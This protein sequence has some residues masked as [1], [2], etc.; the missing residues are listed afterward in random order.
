MSIDIEQACILDFQDI[1]LGILARLYT[2]GSNSFQIS[3]SIFEP[4]W[5]DRFFSGFGLLSMQ[6][7]FGKSY[8][9]LWL[10]DI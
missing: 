1:P 7:N 6:L 9:K 5:F 10:D 3:T 8:V 4:L 2:T